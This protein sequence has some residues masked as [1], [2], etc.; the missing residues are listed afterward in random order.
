MPICGEHECRV[1]MAETL[2][3]RNHRFPGSQQHRRIVVPKVMGGGT[4][5]ISPVDCWSKDAGAIVF[6]AP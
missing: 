1:L 2:R 5:Q 6:M 3:H 4:R